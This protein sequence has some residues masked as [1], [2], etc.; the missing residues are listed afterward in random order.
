MSVKSTTTV[1]NRVSR[2]V[3]NLQEFVGSRLDSWMGAVAKVSGLTL[4]SRVC[5][6]V[7]DQSFA[8]VF[9]A[10]PWI[11]SFIVAFKLPGMFRRVLGEGMTSV[12]VPVF[13]ELTDKESQNKFI[14][15]MFLA[16]FAITGLIC[17]IVSMF[18]VLCVKFVAAG[19][20]DD[21]RLMMTASMLPWCFGYLIFIS[22]LALLSGVLNA[23]KSF[24]LP[25]AVPL[26]LSVGLVLGTWL[27]YF[28]GGHPMWLCYSTAVAGFVQV[29]W[30][31]A[32]IRQYD[33]RIQWP[34]VWHPG[35]KKVL[36]MMFAAWVGMAAS[37]ISV[38]MDT[39]IASWL[40]EGCITWLY[41][42]E[43]LVY[44]PQGTI[45]VAIATVLLPGLSKANVDNDS[46]SYDATLSQGLVWGV[47][48]GVP[49]MLMMVCY[50]EPIV[51][52]LFGYGKFSAHHV[53]AT[54]QSMAA[55]VL[56]LPLM[57][58]NKL[59]VASYFAKKLVRQ[60]VYATILCVVCNAV[61]ALSFMNV[62]QHVALAAAIASGSAVS[63]A[64]LL[65]R[66]PSRTYLLNALWSEVKNNWF[67]WLK[68]LVLLYVASLLFSISYEASFFERLMKLVIM[69][70]LSTGATWFFAMRNTAVKSS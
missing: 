8:Y 37:Q 3:K 70:G 60:S 9:G 47:R 31:I 34:H 59:L 45:G 57:M 1:T 55:M 48:L 32:A 35:V 46:G 19:F 58:M 66:H 22:W 11:E 20:S 2:F 40:P 5:G 68:L 33:F 38:F 28:Y 42:S 49:L 62:Y 65:W 61:I 51:M 29:W 4:V 39:W 6:F 43:R 21:S 63:V 12:V 53:H 56:G 16:L 24:A 41:L 26:V 67:T 50:A 27:V 69:L 23:H 64:Y 25:A 18:P 54:A 10:S 36:A 14:Q 13:S 15:S 44:M 52:L 17:L 30:M 7:R